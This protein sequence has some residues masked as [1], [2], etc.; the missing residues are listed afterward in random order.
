MQKYYQ[1]YFDITSRHKKRQKNDMQP[2][3]SYIHWLRLVVEVMFLVSFNVKSLFREAP[4]ST[5]VDIDSENYKYEFGTYVW[6]Y[7]SYY[8]DMKR[9]TPALEKQLKNKHTKVCLPMNHRL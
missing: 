5:H 3:F 7:I 8:N 1:T 9:N 2:E 6:A 4:K